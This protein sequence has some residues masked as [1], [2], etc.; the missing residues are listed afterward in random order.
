ME[1]KDETA[2]AC[3]KPPCARPRCRARRMCCR[4]YDRHASKAWLRTLLIAWRNVSLRAR[5]ANL[6]LCWQLERTVSPGP[7]LVDGICAPYSP[8]E[9]EAST[10]MNSCASTPGIKDSSSYSPYEVRQHDD[11]GRANWI[12]SLHTHEASATRDLERVQH[13]LV[14]T[15]TALLDCT[16]DI[17]GQVTE[18]AVDWLRGHGQSAS[19]TRALQSARTP[20]NPRAARRIVLDHV[21]GTAREPCCSRAASP[22]MP[23]WLREAADNLDTSR[24]WRAA[25]PQKLDP[26][27]VQ[28]GWRNLCTPLESSSL[29]PLAFCGRWA[30]EN[31]LLLRT[32][33]HQRQALERWFRAVQAI[34]TPFGRRAIRVFASEDVIPGPKTAW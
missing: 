8:Y 20:R 22:E 12:P 31:A 1:F 5:L 9:H 2:P 24:P 26:G 21:A 28:W 14:E 23:S 10:D 13:A 27:T 25:L 19:S 33:V 30:L 29:R 3:T 18:W 16:E 6:Q 4:L 7:T 34:S 32:Q 17:R 11:Q 15:R